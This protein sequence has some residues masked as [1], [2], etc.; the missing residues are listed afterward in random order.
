[1]QQVVRNGEYDYY[2]PRT[3]DGHSDRCTALALAVRASETAPRPMMYP[4]LV[5]C[6]YTQVMRERRNRWLDG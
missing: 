3:K 6:R 1:M 4:I 5:D 2:A